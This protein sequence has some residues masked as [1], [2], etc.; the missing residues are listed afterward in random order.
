MERTL[1]RLLFVGAVLGMAFETPQYGQ[2]GQVAPAGITSQAGIRLGFVDSQR[3]FE[4]S[5]LGRKAI[6]QLRERE[7]R[8]KSEIGRLEAEIQGLQTKFLSQRFSLADEALG[9]M[10]SDINRKVT[11]RKRYEEDALREYELLRNSLWT[12]LRN[13]FLPVVQSL[14]KEKSLA[15][16]FDTQT[17]GV[18]F[19]DPSADLTD[20]VIK[21][22]NLAKI[23]AK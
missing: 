22:F 8:I 18:L 13:E 17:G 5:D 7:T 3:A 20:E 19:V 4:A 6:S 9:Q 15:A 10:E 14:A 23:P 16:V 2:V 12:K 21:R 1:K 11:D